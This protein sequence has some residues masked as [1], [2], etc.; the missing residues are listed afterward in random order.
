MNLPLSRPLL[1]SLLAL[2][3]L[4]SC[5]NDALENRLERRNDAYMNF[6]ERRSMRARARDERYDAWF[7]RIM[8]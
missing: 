6:E 7:D 8:E 3:V 1:L 2:T 5:S 4:S